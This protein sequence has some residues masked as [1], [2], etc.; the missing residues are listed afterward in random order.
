MPILN[1]E[2]F[3][4]I[5]PNIR[6][7]AITVSEEDYVNYIASILKLNEEQQEELSKNWK[8]L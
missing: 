4:Q 1:Q 3:C 7:P 2:K 6:Y 5:F 8:S